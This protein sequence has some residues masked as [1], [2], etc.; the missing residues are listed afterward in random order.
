[1][2]NLSPINKK[3]RT[4]LANRELA[5]SRQVRGISDTTGTLDSRF[6]QVKETNRTRGDENP[7]G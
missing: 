5:V 2:I 3:I 4:T 1:M 7:M 6:E